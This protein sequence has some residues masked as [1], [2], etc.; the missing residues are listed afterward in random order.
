MIFKVPVLFLAFLNFQYISTTFQNRLDL[1]NEDVTY[2]TELV[3]EQ[4][5]REAEIKCNDTLRD[6]ENSEFAYFSF[7]NTTSRTQV[8]SSSHINDKKNP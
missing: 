3:Q 8:S 7:F 2:I 6:V 1:N 5:V 4:L